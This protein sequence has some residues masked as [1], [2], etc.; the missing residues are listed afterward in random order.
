MN[1]E[2][3]KLAG[4]EDDL[5]SKKEK[6]KKKKGNRRKKK[7]NG[8]EDANEKEGKNDKKTTISSDQFIINGNYNLIK[9]LGFGAFG[10]IH[11]AYDTSLKVLRAIKF[12]IAT[13]KNPQLKHEHSI[14]EQL[15]KPDNNNPISS[16]GI[17]GIPKVYLFDRMENKYNYMVMDFLGPSLSDLF[18]FKEKSFS[19]ETVLMLGIQMLTRIEFIH[20]KGFIHRDIKPENFVIGLN[21]R[22]NI[23]HIIDFGLSKR[24][25]DKNTGQHIPYRENR[26]LVGTVRYASINAHLGIEQSRRDDI[27]SIGYVLAYFYLGRLPWQSKM[28][29]G[30]PP[31]NKIM[32]KKLI[33]PPE[34]LCKKMPMEFSYYFHYCKNLKFEDRPD[35]TTLKCLFAD[36]LAS[37]IN[38][39]DEFIFD[40]FDDDNVFKNRKEKELEGSGK[41]DNLI[42]KSDIKEK[43]EKEEEENNEDNKEENNN[44]NLIDIPGD[45]NENDNNS[46]DNNNNNNNDYVTPG[47]DANDNNDNND[48]K[49]PISIFAPTNKGENENDDNNNNNQKVNSL[50]ANQ[51]NLENISIDSSQKKAYNNVAENFLNKIG[52]NDNNDEEK[53]DE[54]IIHLK[55]ANKDNESKESVSESESDSEKQK[56]KNK[57]KNEKGSKKSSDSNYGI[58]KSSRSS[59]EKK[60][61]E[62]DDVALNVDDKKNDDD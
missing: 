10:E 29:K 14:L 38:I 18:Q 49:E 43:S 48:N 21:E 13:H 4:H 52:K 55:N 35:Y 24:Y 11:L 59:K 32:E 51:N 7:K 9:M 19:I 50:N 37:R 39:E 54:D 17:I 36:L 22:S 40:W 45:N 23:V 2:K 60:E 56:K 34:I 62:K 41:S 30:K 3:D 61:K 28:D 58:L 16:D 27:E 31:V 44:K 25:K 15:N 57:E 46:N 20:E 42:G 47:G 33:T 5:V 1:E 8:E 6:K 53:K 12:E 26:H